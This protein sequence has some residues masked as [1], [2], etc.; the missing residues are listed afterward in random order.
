MRNVRW[1]YFI[2]QVK[3]EQKLHVLNGEF[4]FFFKYYSDDIDVEPKDETPNPKN[5][6]KKNCVFDM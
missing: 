1:H 3:K 6:Y 4:L 5:I 2:G